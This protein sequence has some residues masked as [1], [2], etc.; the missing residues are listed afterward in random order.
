MNSKKK[1]VI[2]REKCDHSPMCPAKKACHIGAITQKTKWFFKAEIP[3]IDQDR[4]VG[5]GRCVNF[6]PQRAIKMK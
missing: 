6:C 1:A 2:N 4:C 3:E 5:C